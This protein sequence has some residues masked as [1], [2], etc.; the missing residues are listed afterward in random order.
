MANDCL[1]Y[2]IDEVMI[3]GV[4]ENIEQGSATITNP[5]GWE[6]E[7]VT[8]AKGNHGVKRKRVAPTIKYKVIGDKNHTTKRYE[9][10]DTK[11]ITFRDSMGNRRGRVSLATCIKHGEMGNGDSPEV[12]WGLSSPIQWL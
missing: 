4:M 3:D 1:T 8:A 6:N 10:L 11:Q 2:Q 12:E 5:T 7:M 9:T